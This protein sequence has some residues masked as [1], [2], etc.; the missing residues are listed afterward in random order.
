MHEIPKP[1]M[2]QYLPTLTVMS[3]GQC[4]RFGFYRLLVLQARAR[5]KKDRV[6]VWGIQYMARTHR[7]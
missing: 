5:C 6:R 3:V 7:E 4:R 1:V 2:I